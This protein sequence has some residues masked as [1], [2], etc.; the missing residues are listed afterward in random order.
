MT[1]LACGALASYP[2][3]L[4]AKVSTVLQTQSQ[5]EGAATLKTLKAFSIS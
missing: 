5:S 4:G 3:A 1:T 2:L